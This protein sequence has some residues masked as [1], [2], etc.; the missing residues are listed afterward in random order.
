MSQRI[1]ACVV[2]GCQNG[3]KM[4][5]GW[6]STHYSRWKRQGDVSDPPTR[7]WMRKPRG[8]PL[9]DWVMLSIVKD[10]NGCWIWTGTPNGAGYGWAGAEL[11]HRVTFKHHKGPIPEGKEIDHLCRVRMCCNPDHLEAVPHR[12]NCMRSP[13]TL[14]YINSAKTRCPHGH[15]YSPANTA[16]YMIKNGTARIRVCRTCRRNQ[17]RRRSNANR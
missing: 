2:D 14:A 15:E 12:E 7:M 6:C 8:M 4:R 3:G 10:D 13:F 9:I 5:L 11:V 1:A 16:V 17:A